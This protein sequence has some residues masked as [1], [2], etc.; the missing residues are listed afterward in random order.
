MGK[1]IYSKKYPKTDIEQVLKEA[2]KAS[3]EERDLTELSVL[4]TFKELLMELE[5]AEYIPIPGRSESAEAFIL[6]AKQIAE[7]DEIDIQITENLLG[8]CVELS[9]DSDSMYDDIQ[10]LF[11][12]CDMISFSAGIRDRDITISL[13][14]YVRWCKRHR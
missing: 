10:Y 3:Y 2:E 8:Y 14:Y 4:P 12:R 5:N 6:R 7:D 13:D 1:I 11:S 9:V